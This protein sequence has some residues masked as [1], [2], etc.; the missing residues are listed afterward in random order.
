MSANEEEQVAEDAVNAE[1]AEEETV[2]ELTHMETVLIGLASSLNMNATASSTSLDLT[3]A[4]SEPTQSK[5]C[6][7]LRN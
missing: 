7:P 4:I 3:L 2:A 6:R 5:R 1:E